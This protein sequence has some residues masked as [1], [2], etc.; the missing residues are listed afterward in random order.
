MKDKSLPMPVVATVITLMVLVVGFFLYK[1]I[2][3]GTVGDGKAG[4]VQGKKIG[5]GNVFESP[6]R[7]EY[8]LPPL[9][10][11]QSEIIFAEAS[12][13]LGY[14]PFSSPRAIISQPY[15]DRPGCT[16]CGF[17]QAFGCHVGAKSSILVTKLP[18]A[19]A[20]ANLKL[21]TGAMC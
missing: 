1:G 13:K 20:T 10:P 12:K 9:I 15:N 7:R 16:Y 3:G 2:T 11:D 18:E 17:C 4:N 21:I 14:H 5:D 19:D 6:R 8:P